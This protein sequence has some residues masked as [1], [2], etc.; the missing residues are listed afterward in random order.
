MAEIIIASHEKMA[1]GTAD[2]VR[3]LTGESIS[4]TM[5][6]A[7]EENTPIEETLDRVCARF[8]RHRQWIFAADLHCGSVAQALTVRL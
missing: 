5:L 3:H 6:E 8:D 4:L 7:D 2:A 1:G